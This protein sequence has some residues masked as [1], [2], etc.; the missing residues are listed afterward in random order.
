MY[1]SLSVLLG[2]SLG[3]GGTELANLTHWD[4]RSHSRCRRFGL[5]D[6][7]ADANADRC[8]YAWE[9][10]GCVRSVRAAVDDAL[11]VHTTWCFVQAAVR[12]D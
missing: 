5:H 4:F 6:D 2:T 11:V 1:T 7:D 12:L 3:N 9:G 8:E 10:L